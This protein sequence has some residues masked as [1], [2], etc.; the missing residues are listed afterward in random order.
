MQEIALV[1]PLTISL[2][3]FFPSPPPPSLFEDG[4]KIEQNFLFFSPFS[5]ARE[6]SPSFHS[7]LFSPS[8]CKSELRFESQRKIS[9]PFPTLAPDKEIVLHLSLSPPLSLP[10]CGTRMRWRVFFP[11]NKRQNSHG[12]V[13]L[14]PLPLPPSRREI[15]IEQNRLSPFLVIE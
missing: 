9:P 5:E 3:L 8:P 14:S 4:E 15:E 1:P 2:L 13:L 11:W 7:L 12:R 10:L 6:I